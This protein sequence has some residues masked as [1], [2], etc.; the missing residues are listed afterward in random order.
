MDF[1]KLTEI[2]YN[3]DIYSGLDPETIVSV[4]IQVKQAKYIPQLVKVRAIISDTI[5]TAD[6]KIS[7][8]KE[9]ESDI[10]VEQVSKSIPL[11]SY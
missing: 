9:I 8:I 6:C 2:K 1:S 3:P 11:G 5:F 4:I 7:D 10:L